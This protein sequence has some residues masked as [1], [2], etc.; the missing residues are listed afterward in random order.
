MDTLQINQVPMF[1][2]LEDSGEGPV[3]QSIIR[4]NEGLKEAI[5]AEPRPGFVRGYRN[6]LRIVHT[7]AT[8][9]LSDE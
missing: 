6:R 5:L 4:F 1:T 3:D 8:C 9:S 7:V 2:R